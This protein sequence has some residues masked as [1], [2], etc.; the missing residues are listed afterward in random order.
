MAAAKAA[1]L[2]ADPRDSNIVYA[3]TKAPSNALRPHDQAGA[4]H[5]AVAGRSTAAIRPRTQKYRYTLDHAARHF[6]SQSG[7]SSTTPRNTFFSSTDAATPGRTSARTSRATIKPSSRLRRPHHQGPVQRRI[8]RHGFHACGVAEAGGII[9]AGTDDGLVQ[10]T[11]DGGKTWE[12]VTPEGTPEW[13][14]DQP[15]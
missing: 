8:L 12:K 5:S 13:S 9:W 2:L 10:V 3:T 14:H 11:R 15:D 6:F 1:T 4:E 7:T